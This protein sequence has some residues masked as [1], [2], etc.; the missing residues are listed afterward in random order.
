ME[1]DLTFVRFVHELE[2]L[3]HD[4]LQKLPMGLEE[5]WILSDDVHNVG[6]YDGFVVFTS[7]EFDKAE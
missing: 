5:P 3:V 4:S 6:G 1:R 7:F 2:E